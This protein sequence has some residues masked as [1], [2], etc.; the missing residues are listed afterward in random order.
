M[1]AYHLV[2]NKNF[3]KIVDTSFK[4]KSFT[5]K[6][7]IHVFSE[8]FYKNASFFFPPILLFIIISILAFSCLEIS[9]YAVPYLSL[10]LLVFIKFLFLH[11]MIALQKL[12]K[13][14]FISSKKLFSFSRY[15]SFCNFS[16]SLPHFPDSKEWM[17]VE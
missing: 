13:M 11:Q 1:K 17:E 5:L 14:F 15:S 3:L 2:K 9:L 12:W 7:W 8:Q 16:S 6:V 4:G 10:C